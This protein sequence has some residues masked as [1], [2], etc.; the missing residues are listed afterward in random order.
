MC[1]VKWCAE[2]HNYSSFIEPPAMWRASLVKFLLALSS[3]NRTTFD[4]RLHRND[5]TA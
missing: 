2:R 4:V 1:L 5:G 3:T